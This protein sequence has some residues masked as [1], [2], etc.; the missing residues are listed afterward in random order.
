MKVGFIQFEPYFGRVDRNLEKAEALIRQADAEVLVLPEC[1]N[2]GY[3]FVSREEAWDL[4]EEI[5]GGKTSKLL[6]DLAGRKGQFIVAG[7]VERAGDRLFNA[8]IAVSP[9]GVLGVYRKIHLYNEEKLWFSP[10]DLPFPVYDIGLGKIGVMICFDWFFPEAARMLALKGADVICH[11]ANL[12]LPFCQDGM[13]TRCLEN[14]VFAVTANRTGDERRGDKILTYTGR[15]QITGPQGNIL[16]RASVDQDEIGVVD[17]DVKL[18]RNK[19]INVYNHLL[20]NRRVDMYGDLMK[21]EN[22]E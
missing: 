4:S 12:V 22:G 19:R 20:N 13:I 21:R 7:L 11:C 3:L 16:Y 9:E 1:F 14:R 10:G 5:P 8:A 2:T 15:S 17:M 18:A 6:I